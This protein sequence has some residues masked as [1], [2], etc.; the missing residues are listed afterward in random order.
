MK[1]LH[2]KRMRR[3]SLLLT[4]PFWLSACAVPQGTF[5]PPPLVLTH[6]DPRGRINEAL[7][8]TPTNMVV[9]SDLPKPPTGPISSA[10]EKRPARVGNE[11]ANITLNLNQVSLPNF[12]Q[13]VYGNILKANV[14]V[15]AAVAARTDLVTLRAPVAE[16]PTQVKETARM[17]LKSYGV[18]VNEVGGGLIRIT[19]DNATA[20]YMPE[21]RRGRAQPDTPQ[22]LRPIFQLVEM[23]A[24]SSTEVAGW[25]TR[26]YGTKIT[27]QDDPTRNAIMI[28]GQSDDINSVM[29]SIRVL[30]QPRMRGQNSVRIDP[31]FWSAQELANRLN[32]ILISEGYRSALVAGSPTPIILLPIQAI[33]SIIVFAND[34]AILNHVVEWSRELDKP[35]ARGGGYF[36]YTARYSDAGEL[37]KTVQELLTGEQQQRQ[38]Q[39]QRSQA[40]VAPIP[41]GAVVVGS[42]PPP[43][44]APQPAARVVVNA[45][46]NSLIF[47]GGGTEDY[48]NVLNL[49]EQLDQP[50]KEALI[51][52]TV[53]EV[54]LGSNENLGVEWALNNASGSGNTW[55]GGTLGNLGIG[56]AGLTLLRLNA[57]GNP[58]L[59]INALASSNKARVLSSPRILA[60]N[61]ETA[62]IQ[63]GQEVPIITSQQTSAISGSASAGILQ[64]VQYRQTGVI[65]KVKPIIHAGGRVELDVAQEVSS[66]QATTTGV[67]T[68][69]TISTRKVET[70]LS[71]KDGAT[72]LLGGLM[73]SNDVNG[74]T[75]VPYLKDLP[76]IGQI[77]RVNTSTNARTELIVL[78]TPYIIADDKDAEA[79]T[80]AFRNR[81]GAWARSPARAT[82]TG[83]PEQGAENLPPIPRVPPPVVPLPAPVPPPPPPPAVSY[84]A[85]VVP[86]APVAPAPIGFSVVP[87]STVPAGTLVVV[88][89]TAL[90]PQRAVVPVPVP[91][92]LPLPLPAPKRTP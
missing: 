66:A 34:P 5:L 75:G 29:E 74:D 33:N 57:Q 2:L 40:A 77:F 20:G 61:G 17:V 60:R 35:S 45:A 46:T 89:S 31:I 10:K 36:T 14:S 56:S 30:D 43:P 87:A 44:A 25:L 54:T 50:A 21:I 58:R 39:S 52:V 23:D 80:E 41:A 49:L 76:G 83:E 65:L 9:T 59:V 7:P 24:V 26:M 69:P 38:Q 47:Q 78:I 28:G 16:T 84:V 3:K 70:K 86:P 22:A 71:L 1:K 6:D 37:A 27:L 15:D 12:I 67:A 13:L 55:T 62:T 82:R 51:E 11:R 53:A 68:S 92:P 73:S 63:V 90:L 19:P 88:P 32:E 85:P 18:A 4:L 8:A 72:V 81:L 79:V 42:P 91:L 48:S 64:S